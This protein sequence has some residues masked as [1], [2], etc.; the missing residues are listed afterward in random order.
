MSNA[1]FG[2]PC[3]VARLDGVWVEIHAIDEGDVVHYCDQNGIKHFS[4]L[5]SFKDWEVP[6]QHAEA[7]AQFGHKP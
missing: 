7:M 1:I 5:G 6:E 4:S 3:P 2:H